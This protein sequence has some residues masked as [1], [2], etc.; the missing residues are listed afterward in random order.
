MLAAISLDV[1]A[2][3]FYGAIHG[4]SVLDPEPDPIYTV[5]LPRFFE[6]LSEL[7]VPSTVFLIGMDV[8]RARRT[9]VEGLRETHSE[10]ASHSFSH[11]YRLGTLS[12]A[13][14][15]ADLE[16]AHLAL[17]K[18]APGGRV[19]GFRAPGYNTTPPM[20]ETLVDLGYRYDSSLLPAPSYF[21]AR[22]AAIARYAARGRPSASLVG[23]LRAFSG[24]RGPY[25]TTPA[26]PWKPDPGGGLIELPM[27][28]TPFARLP[29][30]GTSWVLLP[31]LARQALLRFTLRAPEPF[32]FEMHAIDLL[33]GSDPGVPP[34]LARAQPDLRAP[35]T[36][37]IAAFR[38]LFSALRAER[39]LLTLADLVDRLPALQPNG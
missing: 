35:A 31:R 34:S 30:I 15:R 11:D 13:A 19:V 12:R 22:A 38:T 33:D 23:D 17:S 9:L 37:K 3:R 8:A 39:A 16:A 21:A 10:L 27:A 36:E 7:G 26:R 29:L 28:V 14:I 24:P 25:R 6:L 4:M 32:I 2:L 20:L 1:D 18:V 5:A